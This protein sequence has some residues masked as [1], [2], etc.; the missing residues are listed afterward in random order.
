[1]ILLITRKDDIHA[2]IVVGHL[3]K[4]V[5]EFFRFN[6]EDAHNNNI[7]LT[8]DGGFIEN[9]ISKR[10]LELLTVKSVW[11][12]RRSFPEIEIEP[13]SLKS[14]V[15][16]EWLKMYKNIWPFL[17]GCFWISDPIAIELASNKLHQLRLARS[18]GFLV[19]ET[20]ETNCFAE[21]EELASKYEQC[22][23]KPHDGGAINRE[24][25]QMMY[26]NIL[27]DRFWQSSNPSAQ[28]SLCPGIFQ[29]YLAKLY[30]LRI[31]VVG[32][33]VFSAKIDS[34]ASPKSSI[35]WRRYDFAKVGY[36]KIEIP[37]DIANLC[38]KYVK[39]LGLNFGA[40]DMVYTPKGEYYFL[41]INANGQ[42][43]WIE[44]MTEQSISSTIADLLV[45]GGV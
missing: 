9:R 37:T 45:Q 8:L 32:N 24:T 3:K 22:I 15:E 38:V 20:I 26:T 42:W 1:M 6:T 2:D 11:V 34:Q 36:S 30:E 25:K 12:R 27:D 18:L 7:C 29:P 41:E 19:P 35:D 40:I 21:V 33:Q 10:R 28:L 44:L 31:T 43:A 4:K 14:F 39:S 17:S 13:N 5:E 16:Q 23:Y